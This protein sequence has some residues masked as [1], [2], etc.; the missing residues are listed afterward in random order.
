[1]QEKLKAL[2]KQRAQLEEQFQSE[3]SLIEAKINPLTENLERISIR[4]TK[5]NISV[6]LVA[7][8]WTPHWLDEQHKTTPAWQK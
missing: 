1:M 8:V 5:T 7:L 4:P 3:T 2:Q 6:K